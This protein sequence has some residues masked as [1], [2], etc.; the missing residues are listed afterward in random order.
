M[1]D[2][3][4]RRVMIGS[5][6]VTSCVFCGM[7][8]ELVDHF[9]V[10]CDRISPIWYRVSRRLGIEYVPPNSISQVFE[11]FFGWDVR[12]RVRLGM[13]LVWLLGYSLLASFL[14]SPSFWWLHWV[15]VVVT[16]FW[17]SFLLFLYF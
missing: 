16:C 7:A 11:S 17:E 5:S 2:L 9:F 6:T 3:H 15:V 13:I 1:D 4:R 14:Y 10:Y 12:R 8:E